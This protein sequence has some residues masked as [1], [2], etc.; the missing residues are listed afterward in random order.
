MP[1]YLGG[2]GNIQEYNKP[3]TLKPF[4]AA[5]TPLERAQ[6]EAVQTSTQE[7]QLAMAR[8]QK[9]M[10]AYK[11]LDPNM[12]PQEK[13]Q[14]LAAIDP[15]E[16]NNFMQFTAT[17][18]L[19]RVKQKQAE[20][21]AHT[22]LIGNMVEG[23]EQRNPDPTDPK[24]KLEYAQIY[25]YAKSTP[26]GTK[27]LPPPE[28]YDYYGKNMG[29]VVSNFR[30]RTVAVKDQIDE[31]LSRETLSGDMTGPE[32][33]LQWTEPKRH[34]IA[35]EDIM[36]NKP[37]P[38]SGLTPD[39]ISA[40]N[41]ALNMGFP[42]DMV[43]SRTAPIIAQLQMDQPGRH[44]TREMAESKFQRSQI[45]MTSKALLNS[46]EPLMDQL[47][48]S[49][50]ALG[51]TPFPAFNRAK[52]WFAEQTGDPNIVAFNNLRDSFVAEAEK[53]LTGNQVTDTKYLREIGNI[54]A[55]ASNAQLK[56]AIDNTREV[57]RA[58]GE[59]LTKGPNSDKFNPESSSEND[60][61]GIRKK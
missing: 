61:L 52:N 15:D 59:A 56:A 36:R 43:N 22:G 27:G 6:T 55:A 53:A 16:A 21:D 2:L 26:F 18:Q 4:T 17:D 19:N 24:A 20:V 51:N 46:I 14:T 42:P 41:D 3:V 13:Y 29:S 35:L 33:K 60:P 30:D 45:T 10:E 57:L 25:N 7:K 48:E 47:L 1:S 50:K 5:Y 58:R 37:V 44:W 8:K 54:R 32:G 28:E 40:L 9:Y 31:R 34:N 23:W 49:G 39:K 11:S 12:D 38:G